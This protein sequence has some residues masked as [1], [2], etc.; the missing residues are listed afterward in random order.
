ML[1]ATY[2]GLDDFFAPLRTAANL[3]LSFSPRP[4]GPFAGLMRQHSAALEMVSR[5]RLH[6]R[7]PKFNIGSV[8]V[9]NRDVPVR[10]EVVLDLPFGKLLHFRRDIDTPQPKVLV[11]APLS[12]HFATLLEG[13]V[14]T[15]LRDHD[16]YITDW[17]NARDVPASAGAFGVEDYIA[18]LIRFLEEIG[19]G[20]HILA[21]CQ[22]CVQ[23]LAAVAVMSEDGNPAAPRSMVLM[24]GPI[25]VRESP[26]QVNRLAHERPLDWFEKNVIATVPLRYPGAG[27]RV[28]PGFVQLTA[29]MMMNMDRHR[30]QHRKLYDHLAAGEVEEAKKIKE[31]YDEYFAVLDLTAEFYLETIERVFQKAELATGT[32]MWRGRR[33]NPGAI[34]KTA[35]LTVEGGRDDICGLGQ[36]AAA[37][38]LCSAL[39]PHLKRHHMQANVGHYGTF[40]GRKWENEIYPVVRNTILAMD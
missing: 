34:R 4:Q 2:Q 18:Y 25:D 17:A 23:A 28:Y 33:V 26:T 13:T 29:F 31:F 7:R 9:D 37:H 32:L 35:L 10:E 20:A 5:F 39:R 40:N 3:A 8:R 14:R 22:P 12:G 21:V 38:D 36:T 24:A 6:H 1:Y 11:T 30:D 16:V 27:R 19:P 15:L